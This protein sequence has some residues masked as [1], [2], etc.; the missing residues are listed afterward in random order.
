MTKSMSQG[1]GYVPLPR[2]NNKINRISTDLTF[3]FGVI[4]QVVVLPFLQTEKKQKPLR[5]QVYLYSHLF[6]QLPCVKVILTDWSVCNRAFMHPQKIYL[7]KIQVL[8]KQINISKP[9]YAMPI[10]LQPLQIDFDGTLTSNT[11]KSTYYSHT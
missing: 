8:K 1:W 11:E 10:I 4:K 3:I 5:P 2:Y 6:V 7:E 9:H